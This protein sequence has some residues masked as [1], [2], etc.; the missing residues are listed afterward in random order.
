MVLTDKQCMIAVSAMLEACDRN[1]EVI[2]DESEVEG[3]AE[4]RDDLADATC[5]EDPSRLPE[6]LDR[7]DAIE[8]PTE[9]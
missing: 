9:G 7:F 6:F 1:V 5:A 3:L 8:W 4:L 2:G